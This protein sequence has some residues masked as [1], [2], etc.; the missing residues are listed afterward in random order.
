MHMCNDHIKSHLVSTIEQHLQVI[1]RLPLHPLQKIEICQRFIFSKLK[2]QFSIYNLT[3]T[4]VVET[5]DNKFLKFYHRWFQ[6]P[7]SGNIS[8]LSVPRSKL[9]LEIKTLKQICNE[10]KVSNRSILKCWLNAEA[11]KLYE[12]TSNK[13]VKHDCK[14]ND[15]TSENGLERHQVKTKCRSIL[16]KQ[17]KETTWNNFLSLKEQSTIISSIVNSSFAKDITNW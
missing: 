2:W 17:F 13:N 8:H 5:L 7:V 9:G 16:S 3:E 10:C 12:L 15:M 6:I 14:I 1:N 11:Q 4:W